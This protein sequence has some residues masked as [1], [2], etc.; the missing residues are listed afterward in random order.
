LFK[1]CI[2]V[3][4]KFVRVRMDFSSFHAIMTGFEA[5]DPLYMRMARLDFHSFYTLC[6]MLKLE[7]LERIV[8][9]EDA[10]I[11]GLFAWWKANKKA[12]K[13]GMTFKEI[14]GT[15]GKRTVLG[16]GFGMEGGMLFKTYPE[17]FEKK[18]DA[19]TAIAELDALVPVTAA[20]RRSVV[21]EAHKFRRLISRYGYV[22]EFHEAMVVCSSCHYRNREHCPRC[23]GEGFVYGKEAKEAIAFR[24]SNDAHGHIKDAVIRLDKLG[25]IERVGLGGMVNYV[26]DDLQFEMRERGWEKWAQL[27]VE[28]LERP[29]RKLIDPVLAP[30][31][32]SVKVEVMVGKRLSEMKE[33]KL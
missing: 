10:E 5:K 18:K 13:D 2:I 9:M 28:E 24:P 6:G 23:A 7:K 25:L 16:Y 22:R 19:A 21:R 17:F 8:E 11:L 4:P 20:W 15:A 27:V 14:R 3:P 12:L 26:H 30:Q 33:I 1:A 32:L 31:G 29:N